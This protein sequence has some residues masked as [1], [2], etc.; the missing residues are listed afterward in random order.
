MMRRWYPRRRWNRARAGWCRPGWFVVNAGDARWRYAE[1]RGSV[2]PFGD[3]Q[4]FA[5]IGV[6]LF[7]LARAEPMAM[8]H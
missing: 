4:E 1:G 6:S 7:V 2:C 3:E 8:Y 5:Q